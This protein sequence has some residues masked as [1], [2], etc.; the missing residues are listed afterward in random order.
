MSIPTL[1]ILRF[2]DSSCSSCLGCG[3]FMWIIQSLWINIQKNI[4]HAVRSGRNI[5]RKHGWTVN[6]SRKALDHGLRISIEH[7]QENR[8]VESIQTFLGYQ[9]LLSINLSYLH[10]SNAETMNDQMIWLQRYCRVSWSWRFNWHSLRRAIWVSSLNIRDQDLQFQATPQNEGQP[11]W[12]RICTF[13]VL[14]C[15]KSLLECIRGVHRT[16]FS[17]FEFRHDDDKN[18]NSS[19]IAHLLFYFMTYRQSSLHSE[20]FW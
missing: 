15:V 11:L 6:D 10:E 14:W 13:K 18:R 12:I 2:P 16:A 20:I 19:S 9:V 5:C 7:A 4:Q 17:H 1:E 3:V 8:L